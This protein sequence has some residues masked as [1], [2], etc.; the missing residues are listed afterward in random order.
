MRKTTTRDKI[1][2]N[3][4]R[5]ITCGE[6]F[7]RGERRYGRHEYKGYYCKEHGGK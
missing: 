1:R 5:C 4:K 3:S 2:R 7:P 6:R